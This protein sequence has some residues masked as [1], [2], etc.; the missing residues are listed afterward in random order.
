MVEFDFFEFLDLLFSDPAELGSY[1]YEASNGIVGPASLIT[2]F[3]VLL[4]VVSKNGRVP[5]SFP[6]AGLVSSLLTI[7]TTLI[8]YGLKFV[9]NLKTFAIPTFFLCLFLGILII[10]EKNGTNT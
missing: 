9:Q 10:K 8:L 4:V 7:V 3:I 5:I 6:K 1:I 2:T